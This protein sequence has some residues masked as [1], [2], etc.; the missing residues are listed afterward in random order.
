MRTHRLKRNMFVQIVYKINN[1]NVATFPSFMRI[2]LLTLQGKY[3]S[4]E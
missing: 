2:P 4:R 3:C 1:M